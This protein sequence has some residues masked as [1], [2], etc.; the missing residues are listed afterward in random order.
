MISY[1][2]VEELPTQGHML[3]A[4]RHLSSWIILHSSY[5]V[6]EPVAVNTLYSS[7]IKGPICSC[8]WCHYNFTLHGR[9]VIV[10]V[11]F[12]VTILVQHT[13]THARTHAHVHTHTHT[14]YQDEIPFAMAKPAMG[15]CIPVDIII[16]LV[17]LEVIAYKLFGC[18]HCWI[19]T[20]ISYHT[21]LH[22]FT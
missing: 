11:L 2:Q 10:K 1:Q 18:K 21:H 22:L 3:S 15:M 16:V 19:S 12:M 14:K 17:N 7:T 13:H 20:V 9:S 8:Y 5:C 4:R 6:S